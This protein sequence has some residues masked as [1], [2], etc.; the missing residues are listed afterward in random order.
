MQN[1][2]GRKMKRILVTGGGGFIG[3]HPARAPHTLLKT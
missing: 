1:G 2:R 3:G